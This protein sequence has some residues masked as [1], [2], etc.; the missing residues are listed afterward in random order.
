M[1]FALPVLLLVLSG[2]AMMQP[3]TAVVAQSRQDWRAVATESDR[4]RLR[5]WRKAFTEALQSARASGH[6]A[7][8]DREGVLLQPDAALAGGPIPN[9]MYKCR[10]IKVGARSSGMLDFV[11]YPNF[12]CRVQPDGRLQSFAKLT[13]SQRQ[14][15]LIFPSDGLRQ[16]FLG[17]LMLGDEAR[18]MHYGVDQERDVAGLVERIGPNRWRMVMPSPHF[19]SRLDV[20]ELVPTP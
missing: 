15:G 5:D 12:S 19:E 13:G 2:C 9:G 1:R 20:M 14:V 4:V 17:T 16:I 8:I 10:V 6:S 7:E 18:A 3:P 11:A